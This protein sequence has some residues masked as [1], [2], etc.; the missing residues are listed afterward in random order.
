MNEKT[1][2]TTLLG[3]DHH[4]FPSD[5]FSIDVFGASNIKKTK[6]D[7]PKKLFCFSFYPFSL[8]LDISLLFLLFSVVCV[9]RM[10]LVRKILSSITS[11]KLLKKFRPKDS[12]SLLGKSQT[13]HNLTITIHPS[14]WAMKWC[15]TNK[16]PWLILLLKSNLVV[17]FELIV[18]P[19]II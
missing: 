19:Y 3:V 9:G 18:Q 17:L 1:F 14:L 10:W 7:V 13:L 6:K 5:E 8:A 4:L 2:E 11:S 15:R 12:N 16:G